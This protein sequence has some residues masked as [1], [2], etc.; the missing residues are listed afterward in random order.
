M[1]DYSEIAGCLGNRITRND[2]RQTAREGLIDVRDR[3]MKKMKQYY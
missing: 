3:M 2:Y 1:R